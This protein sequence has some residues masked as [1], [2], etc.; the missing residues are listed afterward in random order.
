MSDCKN[1]DC[2]DCKENYLQNMTPCPQ[3]PGACAGTQN[4]C[5]DSTDSLCVAYNGDAV[6]CGSTSLLTQ[7]MSV[8][9]ALK[10]IA[11][12]FC[13][14]GGGSGGGGQ[15]PD[16]TALQACCATNTTNITNLTTTVSNLSTLLNTNISNV[17]NL[18]NTV[19]TIQG[20][21]TTIQSSITTIQGD[22]TNIQN[23]LATLQNCCNSNSGAVSGTLNRIA[24]FTPNGNTVGD[25]QM[26]DDGNVISVNGAVPSS[27]FTI[28][29]DKFLNYA[30]YFNNPNI[31]A[32][33]I[34]LYAES[35]GGTG[36]NH[37]LQA[38]ASGGVTSY[39][40]KLTASGSQNAYGSY[41][42]SVGTALT[43]GGYFEALG[44]SN[45]SVQ[46]KDGTEGTAGWYLR[47]MT[48]D[49]KANWA[50]INI[51]EVTNGLSSTLLGAPNG[52][53]TLDNNSKLTISQM[54]ISVMDYKGTFD[55]TVP[56]PPLQDG[57][58]NTGDVY[59]VTAAGT[60]TFGPGNTIT[61]GVGDWMIYNGTKWEKTLG[62]N[63]GSGTVT[64]VGLALGST[65]TDANIS[66]SPITS[67]GNIQLNLPSASA[68]A[69]GLLTSAHWSLF[70]DKIGG[71]GLNNYVAKFTPDGKNIGISQIRDDGSNI[72]IGKNIDQPF[73][74]VDIE[75][76]KEMGLKLQIANSTSTTSTNAVSFTSIQ[77]NP[78]L[79]KNTG[80]YCN[81]AGSNQLNIGID[82]I[83]GSSTVSNIGAK[84]DVVNAAGSN[85]G[86]YSK[87]KA[88]ANN[89]FI[90]LEKI[91]VGGDPASSTSSVVGRYLRNMTTDGKADWADIQVSEV[92]G[93]VAGAP[94]G[95]ADY[96]ARWTPDGSTIGIGKIR[97]DG[98]YVGVNAAPT[99]SANLYIAG[100]TT[101]ALQLVHSTV[102]ANGSISKN[103]I[104]INVSGPLSDNR[105]IDIVVSG[106]TTNTIGVLSA[107]TGTVGTTA[108]GG[109][110]IAQGAGTLYSARLKDPTSATNKFL[111]SM[112]N[113]GDANWV[114]LP[115][116]AQIMCSDMF[117]IIT[118]SVTTNASTIKAFWA[119]PCDG[120]FTDMFASL[121]AAQVGGSAFTVV[122]RSSGSTLVTLTFVNGQNTSAI[123]TN[124]LSFTKGN[125]L[126]F[127]V[128]QVGDGSARGL[129]VT[130]N[131]VRT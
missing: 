7:G 125:I 91:A 71:N 69:R 101:Q 13:T 46:L 89:Y 118:A 14:N 6:M 105:G 52:I 70:N 34:A 112:T 106:G 75:S 129:L 123:I 124:T 127:Y 131:Y 15:A 97:D 94:N 114:Y 42:T 2:K 65:G 28:N 10:N 58:G 55:P 86:V 27:K 25:S 109:Q 29:A 24:K 18:T 17:T 78:L 23:V 67:S 119:A 79:A 84:I 48:T 64:S 43:I 33:N 4:P 80:I 130:L 95:T 41:A 37:G 126:E 30:G 83:A 108:W 3:A 53:A 5:E 87:V 77:N 120:T 63:I 72:A 99:A 104:S 21:V 59:V 54:P 115:D 100:N 36:A 11:Q 93:A 90:Q 81:T 44:A 122:I 66:N 56:S 16:L 117:S 47:N 9:D 103:A 62:N 121:F 111:K 85:I 128:T 50:K 8:H 96:V 19:T 107:A 73:T 22:I 35:A 98:S 12:Y 40:A 74:Y 102:P 57:V 110:L 113:D 68:S 45:Y 92:T 1:N 61:V 88:G 116:S 32:S 38:S 49:G 26:E 20:D 76:T 51:T 39:G 60:Y 31:V 82:L